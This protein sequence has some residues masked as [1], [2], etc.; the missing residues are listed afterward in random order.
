MGMEKATLPI[1]THNTKNRTKILRSKRDPK[2]CPSKISVNSG[3]FGG[4]VKGQKLDNTN[5][6]LDFDVNL[7]SDRFP[8][9]ISDLSNSRSPKI[10]T[11]NLFS[12]SKKQVKKNKKSEKNSQV[13]T[14]RDK[15]SL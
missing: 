2:E 7:N 4:T 8:M 9:K 15:T 3:N 10:C 5:K 13:S 14:A 12:D 11:K 1:D 6:P